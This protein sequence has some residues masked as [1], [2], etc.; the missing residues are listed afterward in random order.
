MVLRGL[1]SIIEDMVY[2][3][4]YVSR[5]FTHFFFVV[6]TSVFCRNS[7]PR[8]ALPPKKVPARASKVAG[9]ASAP[10]DVDSDSGIH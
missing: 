5:G 9:E 4:F 6:L 8:K 7:A 2:V 3:L 10:L 1:S